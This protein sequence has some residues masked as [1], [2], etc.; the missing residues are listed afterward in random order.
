VQITH[1][2]KRF[3]EGRATE[4]VTPSPYRQTP[5]CPYYAECG[6][7]QLRHVS[8]EYQLTLKKEII[9]NAM[10]R[11]GGF[12]DFA[13]DGITGM[14]APHRYRNK[15]IFQIG[16]DERGSVCGFYAQ[17]SHSIIP[18][19]DCLITASENGAINGALLEF[20]RAYNVSAYDEATHSGI[21]R[22]IFTRKSFSTGEIMIVISANASSIPH[23]G[24]LIECLTNA[25]ENVSS[26]I[27][28]ICKK[29]S[30]P[31]LGEENVTLWGSDT[32]T[33][34]LC[35]TEF[36]ISPRS[37]FQINPIQTE[38]LYGKALEYAR[39]DKSTTVMDIYCGIGTIS[40]CAAKQ[41]KSVI[42]I[43]IVEEA[44]EDAKKNAL[45]NNIDNAHFYASSAENIVPK[46]IEQGEMPDIVI[47]D[48]PRKGSDK[49]TLG[50]IIKAQPKRIVYV[51][52]NCATLARDA[53]ILAD[54]G[55]KIIRAEGFDLFPH[56]AHVETVMLFEK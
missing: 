16:Q 23:S 47:L 52:C 9:N 53:R 31:L 44:I 17:R 45:R 13:A 49:A 5:D 46:L 28:N 50:A 51:S 21:I 20:M 43:E 24:K 26:I 11:L 8:Y 4:I 42:G 10:R 38:K 15:S 48:P 36:I 27:L 18:I 7:C 14:D 54:G 12:S 33:D 6:G 2:K 55:Y 19:S 32:I 40:L 35:G 25:S 37:F 56:T 34:T 3:A 39:A 29:R 22:R 41:A 1:L 30:T